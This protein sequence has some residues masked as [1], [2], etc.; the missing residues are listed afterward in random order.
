MA[1]PA[2]TSCRPGSQAFEGPNPPRPAARAIRELRDVDIYNDSVHHPY[3]H[4]VDGGVSD[5]LGM[6]GVLDALNILEALHDAGLPSPLD[7]VRRIIV[8]VVNSLSSPPNKWDES[9]E[10]PGTVDVMLKAAGTPID[11]YSYEAVELLKDIAA[12]WREEHRLRDLAG[13][14]TNKDSPVC[15]AVTPPDA[16]I[17]AI[18]VSFAQ[19]KDKA[20]RD[21]LNLQPTSFV[22]PAEAVDRLRAAAGKIILESPEFQRLLKETGAKVVP[23]PAAAAPL[24]SPAAQ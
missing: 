6:R 2:T 9:E 24:N 21:Y 10:P 8:L 3:I 1:A 17:H 18:D 12:R 15:A 13:C 20:E 23:V 14:S 16:E 7:H 22:L 5:N 19:L 4:L 11:H